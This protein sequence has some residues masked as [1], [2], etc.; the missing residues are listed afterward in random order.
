MTTALWQDFR[1]WFDTS[2]EAA[3]YRHLNWEYELEEARLKE[4]KGTNASD[5]R[6]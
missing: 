1:D 5:V 4:S 6:L 2:D 3:E